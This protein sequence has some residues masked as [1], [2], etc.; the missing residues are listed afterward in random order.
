MMFH[1]MFHVLLI[2]Q[3]VLTYK[4]LGTDMEETEE[5]GYAI[6]KYSDEPVSGPCYETENECQSWLECLPL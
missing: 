6:V 2:A 3:S 5:D 1:L 4:Y